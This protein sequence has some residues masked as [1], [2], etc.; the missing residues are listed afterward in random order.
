[1][2]LVDTACCM[3][4]EAGCKAAT[5]TMG[6]RCEGGLW[7]AL[8][9]LD[10]PKALTAALC[11]ADSAQERLAATEQLLEWI[12]TYLRRIAPGQAWQC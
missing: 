9:A 11:E 10:A 12:A 5:E 7:L 4:L 2:A 3:A 6:H 1:L 8:S